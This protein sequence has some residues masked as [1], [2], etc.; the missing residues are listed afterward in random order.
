MIGINFLHFGDVT[1]KKYRS[2]KKD[3]NLKKNKPEAA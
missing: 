3:R 1:R 2:I